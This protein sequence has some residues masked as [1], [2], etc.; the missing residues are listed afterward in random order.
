MII[1]YFIANDDY[2]PGPYEVTFMAGIINASFC[3]YILN[4]LTLEKDE[5][6]NLTIN[7]SSLPNNVSVDDPDQARVTIIDDDGK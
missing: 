7:A 2:S 5:N 4:D 6:F 3:V 1:M